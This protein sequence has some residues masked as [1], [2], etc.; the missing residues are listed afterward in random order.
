MFTFY[1]SL[2]NK[3]FRLQQVYFY[4]HVNQINF[5]RSIPMHIIQKTVE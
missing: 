2:E 4:R 5:E 1:K 3:I